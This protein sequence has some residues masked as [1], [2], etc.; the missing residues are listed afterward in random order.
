MALATTTLSTA[1]ALLDKQVVLASA[2]SIAVGRIL[3]IDQEDMQVTG[4]WVS[5]TTVPVLRGVGG[6]QQIAHVVTANV[7]HGLSS[8]F[9]LPV[10]QTSTTYPTQ[11]P[12][13]IQSITATTA[14]L[15]LPPAGCDLRVILNGTAA[16]TLTVPVPTKDMDGTMLTIISNGA[17]AHVPTFTGGVG[18][19]GASYDAF[20]YNST[21]TVALI[22][23]AANGVWV[24]P[25]T[26]AIT[27]TVTNITAGVA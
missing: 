26:P 27:G 13:L 14:T 7:T 2:T 20:T 8:D 23:Y 16:I 12:T 6:T 25:A 3:R 10:A 24:M 22:A 17:A 18:G 1:V 15:V 5:G 9:S 21:G 19:A 11:R 4:A